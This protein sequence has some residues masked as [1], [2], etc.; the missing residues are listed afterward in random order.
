MR[1]TGNN[2]DTLFKQQPINRQAAIRMNIQIYEDYL[3]QLDAFFEDTKKALQQ[4]SSQRQQ[5]MLQNPSH[6]SSLQQDLTK[7]ECNIQ[8]L[9]Q[10]LQ[11]SQLKLNKHTAQA[12]LS[13]FYK[14][15]GLN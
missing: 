14:Q 15:L 11:D 2:K 3:Q 9:Q 10:M 13:E 1:I 7:L 8:Q 5:L 12:E 4:L 6:D